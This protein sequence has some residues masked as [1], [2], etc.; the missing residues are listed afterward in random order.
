[1]NQIYMMY[2]SI[3]GKINNPEETFFSLGPKLFP[4]DSE[5]HKR[6]LFGNSPKLNDIPNSKQSQFLDTSRKRRPTNF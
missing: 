1:M 3:S 2:E 6:M 4:I 5:I